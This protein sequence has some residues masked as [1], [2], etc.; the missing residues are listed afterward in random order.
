MK[1]IFKAHN[2]S[3]YNPYLDPG[4]SS[5][6]AIAAMRVGHSL[7]PSGVVLRYS[8]CS[9]INPLPA[10]YG[11]SA[12]EPALRLCNTYWQLQVNSLPIQSQDNNGKPNCKLVLIEK[13]KN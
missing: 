9:E 5:E 4:I 3:G 6:F 1:T 2:Q 8:N 11:E 7:V 12:G 10:A 13:L